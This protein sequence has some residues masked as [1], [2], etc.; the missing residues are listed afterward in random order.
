MPR[1]SSVLSAVGVSSRIERLCHESEKMA[2]GIL[3]RRNLGAGL[4]LCLDQVHARS[5]LTQQAAPD[6][7]RLQPDDAAVFRVRCPLNCTASLQ[8]FDDYIH[9]LRSQI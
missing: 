5:A 3:L 9:G 1:S 6:G 2:Y 4:Q 8:V 7:G